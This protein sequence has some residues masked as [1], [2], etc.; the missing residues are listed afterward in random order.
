MD[1]DSLTKLFT[2]GEFDKS[3]GT[4][5]RTSLELGIPF[6]VVMAD[7]DHFKKVNDGHGHQAGDAVL[8]E[9]SARLMRILTG[10]GQAFR[11]GGEEVVI[12]LPNHDSDEALSTAERCRKEIE[13]APMTNIAVTASFGVATAP[14]HGKDVSSLLKAADEALYDAKNRGRNLVRLHGEPAPVEKAPRQATRK[15]AQAGQLTDE[16]RAWIRRSI[17]MRVTPKCPKDEVYLEH[18]DI[19]SLGDVGRHFIVMCPECGLSDQ[20]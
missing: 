10:K 19:T 2:R 6:S 8:R 1:Q 14:I 13:S 15:V 5:L 20:V 17:L 3:A 18:Q 16:Q 12:L 9:V 7:V 4:S 11:Y